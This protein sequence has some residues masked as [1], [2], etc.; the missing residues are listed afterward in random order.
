VPWF[1]SWAGFISMLIGISVFGQ[2][3]GGGL[4]G[5]RPGSRRVAIGAEPVSLGYDRMNGLRFF[6]WAVNSLS[7]LFGY[8]N[9]ETAD[10]SRNNWFVAIIT[11][12]EGWHNNHHD[13]PPSG[14]ATRVVPPKRR[15]GRN[16]PV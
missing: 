7:H 9:H 10:R 1:F 13:D 16:S 2:L 6:T 15:R 11:G 3:G 8:R 12:G 5:N 14:L 4:D